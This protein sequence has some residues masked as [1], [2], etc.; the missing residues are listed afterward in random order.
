VT[1]ADIHR[2]DLALTSAQA[3]AWAVRIEVAQKANPDMTPEALIHAQGLSGK[4]AAAVLE[5]LRLKESE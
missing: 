4:N 5:A 1:P 2:T 3:I